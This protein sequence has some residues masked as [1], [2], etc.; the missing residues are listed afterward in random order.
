MLMGA[1]TLSMIQ[2]SR[3]S[4][5]RA[6]IAQAMQ[7]R[8]KFTCTRFNLDERGNGQ[9]CY[10]IDADGW[11]FSFPIFSAE[12]KT[13]GRSARI[14]GTTWDILGALI[15]GSITDDDFENTGRELPKLYEGRATPST[16]IWARSNRSGRLFEQAVDAL[17]DGRQP[18]IAKLAAVG[19]LTRNTG[20]DGNGTFGTKT[21]LAFEND[22]PLRWAL[23]P[24]M[25]SAYMMR[26]FAGDLLHHLS[27]AKGGSRAVHMD[28]NLQRYLGLG[29]ASAIGLSY[30]VH[31]HP[32][33][34]NRWLSMRQRLVDAAMRLHLEPDGA[35]VAMLVG[36][37]KK[38]VT[39]RREDRSEYEVFAASDTVADGLEIIQAKL[40][41]LLQ[42]IL[43]QPIGNI[44]TL[45]N[46]CRSLTGMVH[47][48]ALET[49]HSLLIE[50]VP[51]TADDLVR[52]LIVNEEMCPRPEMNLGQLRE[53]IDAE[54]VWVFNF[55][56]ES[57][58]SRRYVWYKSVTA[59]E[60]RRGPR[61]E[62]IDAHNIGLDLPRLVKALSEDLRHCPRSQCVAR[63][64]IAHPQ[65]RLIAN[66]IQ[67]LA[68]LKYH[69]PHADIM[70]E[71]FIPA[72]VVRLM[73]SGIH[74]ID[75][76]RDFLGRFIRGVLFQGAPLPDEIASGKADRH[77]FYPK[78]PV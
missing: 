35:Q 65:H 60:P 8:W 24:Q 45:E 21:F 54:Y 51:D 29:N 33:L 26:V 52:S 76:T 57:E 78:E 47:P 44:L 36:L 2:P 34:I 13:A 46:L 64:L 30:F 61:E 4:V 31:N 9:A 62:V 43:S 38:A 55:D 1:E 49:L 48:E 11:K 39:Y 10:I 19:Y 66:R 16:L 20:L 63:F 7:S 27:R 42:E 5:S 56:L 74:G 70:S 53:I 23:G 68:G 71:D 25:L 77:W 3:I 58:R 67:T 69:S 50:L 14:I 17:A 12:P 59:E 15:E 72:H 75:K 73:N 6:L 41:S 32:K 40:N 28:A 18:D 37:V 22:H